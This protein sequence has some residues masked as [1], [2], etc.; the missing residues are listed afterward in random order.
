MY[1]KMQEEFRRLCT[2]LELLKDR[3][4]RKGNRM[5][6]CKIAAMLEA[7]SHAETQISTV[8][9]ISSSMRLNEFSSSTIDNTDFT[10]L[11]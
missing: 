2:Q 4:S 3:N 8:Q 7:A 6:I 11:K 1:Q 10:S 5:I 9:A